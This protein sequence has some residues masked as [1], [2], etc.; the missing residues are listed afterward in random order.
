MSQSSEL[1]NAF[2]KG[3]AGLNISGDIFRSML[4]VPSNE[5]HTMVMVVR[6]LS[7][8]LVT[9]VKLWDTSLEPDK[10][11]FRARAIG[12]ETD[13]DLQEGQIVPFYRTGEFNNFGT[14]GY[15]LHKQDVTK[16]S[17]ICFIQK[18]TPVFL[19]IDNGN[20]TGT[21]GSETLNLVP[22]DAL[23]QFYGDNPWNEG[24]QYFGIKITPTNVG[25]SPYY[26]I[27]LHGY[28]STAETFTKTAGSFNF[29]ID[30]DEQGKF[31]DFRVTEI[32]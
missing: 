24:R 17:W 29:E 15:E 3:T 7:N 13:D 16:T 32:G 12:Y 6:G 20:G 28:A 4:N 22:L 5:D 25:S 11:L 19:I 31:I 21:S 18:P 2:S 1:G 9:A 14:N 23:T 26:L 27:D 8:G 10:E 30:V